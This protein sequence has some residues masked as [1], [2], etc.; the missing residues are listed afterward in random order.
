MLQN[1]TIIITPSLNTQYL[2]NFSQVL[3]ILPRK[4]KPMHIMEEEPSTVV[5][6]KYSNYTSMKRSACIT[7]SMLQNSYLRKYSV[8]GLKLFAIQIEL[9]YRL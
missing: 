3:R 8:Y 1:G 9:T 2:Y 4:H 6:T 7:S 5:S